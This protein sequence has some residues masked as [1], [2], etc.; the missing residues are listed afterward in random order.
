MLPNQNEN[1]TKFMFKY[2][3]CFKMTFLKALHF[4]ADISKNTSVSWWHFTQKGQLVHPKKLS[5]HTLD[6][7]CQEPKASSI[8]HAFRSFAGSYTWHTE[9]SFWQAD[10]FLTHSSLW[11]QQPDPMNCRKWPCGKTVRSPKESLWLFLQKN[12]LNIQFPFYNDLPRKVKISNFCVSCKFIT[13]LLLE[14]IWIFFLFYDFIKGKTLGCHFYI[15][16][17]L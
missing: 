13:F 5:S 12:N 11:P 4:V 17:S 2:S 6:S 16:H 9:G 3:S 8:P 15:S 1:Q 7:F 14:L 10:V